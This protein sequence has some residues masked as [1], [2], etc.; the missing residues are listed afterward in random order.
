MKGFTTRELVM[1]GVFGALWGASEIT[2]GSVLHAIHL[3]LTGTVMT[4]IGMLIVCIARAYVPRR[5]STLFI[6]VITALLKVLSIGS[7][8]LG[9]ML[10]I[11]A[12]AIVAEIVLSVYG[13]PS[14]S[15]FM[16]ASASAV[17]W[18]LIHPFFTGLLFFGSSFPDVM[19]QT[20]REGT[21]LFGPNAKSAIVAVIAG[22]VAIRVVV[23]LIAGALASSVVALLGRRSTAV[24]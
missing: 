13:K 21:Q 15:A 1:M 9:P 12:E 24:A 8:V 2:L 17:T 23:G 14:L 10:G 16:V 6:G 18:T 5:G 4:G 7:V 11:L 20:M 3:P 19:K 22:M